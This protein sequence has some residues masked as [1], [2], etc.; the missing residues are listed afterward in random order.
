MSADA[1][2]EV[3]D[4]SYAYGPRQVLNN[5]GFS[6]PVGQFAVLLGP[7]GAGKTTLFSLITQLFAFR[8]GRIV[9]YGHDVS[10]NP[11]AAL[12]AI[13]VVFQQPTL[14]L[15]LSVRQ[16]LRY[17]AAL[18]GLSTIDADRLG[19]QAME[20]VSMGDHLKTQARH[21][22][23]GQRRRVEI[24]RSL[25]HGPRFLLLDEPTV[26]LDVASRQTILAHVRDLCRSTGLGVLWATHL[27]D[28]AESGDHLIVLD[29]G[30]VKADGP[31]GQVIAQS[32]C[33]TL[34]AAF[35]KLVGQKP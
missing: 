19:T 34:G 17:H 33:D 15:D 31:L 26:G 27:L 21:L 24:G 5:V 1:A 3:A 25:M 22:S 35:A 8:Q 10:Q 6:V 23:G 2:L 13:G 7:N 4:L 11:L 29:K 14:D 12:A 9:V 16:N 18:H 20:R 28:E 30:Q 32:G